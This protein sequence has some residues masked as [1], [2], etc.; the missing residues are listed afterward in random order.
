MLGGRY[1]TINNQTE[2]SY[3]EME[4]DYAVTINKPI[5]SIVL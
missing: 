5:I 2:I 4:Y 1:G 3:I